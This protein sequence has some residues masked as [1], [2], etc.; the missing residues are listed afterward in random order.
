MS[1]RILGFHPGLSS[2]QIDFVLT[3]TF[4]KSFI[5]FSVA[6]GFIFLIASCCRVNTNFIIKV[7]GQ[8]LK[9][10]EVSFA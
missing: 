10:Q 7:K 2:V 6:T 9:G 4:R 8:R 1:E 3:V 5:R